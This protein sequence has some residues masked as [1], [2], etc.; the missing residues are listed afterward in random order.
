[1]VDS[2]EREL[3]ISEINR[4]FI[5]SLDPSQ[6]YGIGQKTKQEA[7]VVEEINQKKQNKILEITKELLVKEE[8]GKGNGAA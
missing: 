1:M 7:L 8:E 6:P 4:L 2:L 3:I 5:S